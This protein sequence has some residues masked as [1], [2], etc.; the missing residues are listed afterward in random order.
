MSDAKATGETE[1]A[2]EHDPDLS[3]LADRLH[4]V[5][6]DGYLTY[7]DSDDSD[8]L[9]VSGFDA[10]D[11]FSTLVTPGGTHLLVSGLE[12]GRA[13]SESRADSVS[14]NAAFDYR[15]LAAEY[16]PREAKHR[17][18]AA[19][20]ASVDPDGDGDGDGAGV[21]RVLVPEG[22]PLG[23]AEG[24]REQG[25][26]V[27]VETEG[28]VEEVRATKTDREVEHVRGAQAANERAMAAA[29]DLLRTATAEDGTLYHDG[30][31]LTSERVTTAIETTL[32]EHGC[33]LDE[34]IVAGGADGA[35]P[36]DRGS[37]P[38]PANEP[39]VIDIFPQS[40]ATKYH[41]DMT[42]TF[43]VGEPTD[44]VRRRHEDTLDA[45]AAAFDA[46]EPGTTG[47]AVHDAVCDVYEERGYDT[48]R[49]NPEAETGFIHSTGHGVGLDV[50]E[51]PSV[52]PDGGEL[53]PGH[54]ITIEPG[55]Y[56]PAHGGM[57]VEDLVLVTES[58]YENLTDYHTDLVV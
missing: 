57:R 41:A 53:A 26:T 43:V 17:V 1:D 58:G 29:E 9:Y 40:K 37:G 16:G 19:F 18:L 4:E 12:Y 27:E 50:H 38:L 31:V 34:T 22:F 46:V 45:M 36:H 14:R 47:E 11:P 54:V 49:S 15:D 52:S 55:L 2:P 3:T 44:A 20:L 23:T 48:L 24:L 21:E 5:G 7:D 51:R 56:D 13:R 8:Q 32:L 30:E 10:P 42:R 28:V 39:I 33:A 35:D 6:A 25:V